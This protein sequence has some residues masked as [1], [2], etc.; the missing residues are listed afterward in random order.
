MITLR[1]YPRVLGEKHIGNVHKMQADMIEEYT[2]N[3]EIESRIGYFYDWNHDT[4]HTQLIDLHPEQDEYKIPMDI[5]Y[6]VASRQTMA[7]DAITYHL[8]LRPS[9]KCIV[10]YYEECFGNR[11]SAVYPVG[12]Y[13]DIQD[14]K[15][16]WNR[17]LVC[18]TANENDP[19]FPNFEILRCD[20][21]LDAIFDGV[22]Y[23]IPIVLRSQNSYNSGLWI[24]YRIETPEDQQQ[25]IVPLNRLT[26]NIWYNK[27]YL[28]DAKVDQDECRA[29][30]VSKVNRLDLPGCA[31]I[32]LAQD[33]FDPNKDYIEK[34]TGG[35]IVGLWAD[36]YDKP[37]TP[38][39]YN[40]S[41]IPTAGV[42]TC[43]GVQ[44]IKVGG[45]YKKFTI[46]FYDEEGIPLPFKEGTWSFEI[47]GIE[48]EPIV[49]TSGISANQ[50]KAKLPNNGLWI[51]KI[52]TVKY[53]TT[54]VEPLITEFELSVV[55]L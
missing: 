14:S 45:T 24:K 52:M 42:I 51:N 4:H 53:T 1:S 55:A 11:Y 27:R 38:E 13:V 50:I 5:K 9:Q 31:M 3:N 54:E 17:W 10:D 49:S 16:V 26:E 22:Q 36:Y 40:P 32:T 39:P 18:A 44:E 35:N 37:V 41:P 19:Q 30:H 20:Y 28:I 21:V 43:A 46:D 34:D 33:H 23:K 47:D 2:W 12:L 29:W 48:I 8:Q 6:I 15:G 25:F 7:K